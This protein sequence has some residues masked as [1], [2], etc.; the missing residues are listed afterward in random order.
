M[1]HS[2]SKAEVGRIDKKCVKYMLSVKDTFQIQLYKQVE[3][4]MAEITIQSTQEPQES[5]CQYTNSRHTDNNYHQW[6]ERAFHR[7]NSGEFI[8]IQ[9]LTTYINLIIETQKT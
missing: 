7:N 5:W 3:S 1:K 2:S 4:T 6:P 9:Q 8:R